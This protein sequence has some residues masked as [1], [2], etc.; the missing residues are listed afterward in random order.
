MLQ[1]KQKQLEE[2]YERGLALEKSGQFAQAAVAYRQVLALDKEDCS[3]ASIRLA[4][5]GMGDTPKT[6][7]KAYI[8]TLFDQYADVFE[9]ILVDSLSYDVPNLLRKAIETRF[10]NRKFKTL[11]DLGCGTGLA[12]E[13]FADLAEVKMGVDISQNMVE[14]AAEREIYRQLFTGDIILFL[15]ENFEKKQWDIIIAADVLPYMGDLRE[16]FALIGNSLE[17]GGIFAFSTENLDYVKPRSERSIRAGSYAVGPHQRF[18]HSPSYIS[19]ILADTSLK[20][21]YCADITVRKE[22]GEPVPGQLFL[23]VK[24]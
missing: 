13:A 23:A 5:M 1:N 24:I 20:M 7:P 4:S 21:D 14:I 3:G 10:S 11:L 18:A 2:A 6:A 8:A 16:F 17:K 19:E 12:G 15:Q 9:M 22:Q